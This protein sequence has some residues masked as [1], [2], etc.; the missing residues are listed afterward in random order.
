MAPVPGACSPPRKGWAETQGP[1]TSSPGSVVH[2]WPP[3]QCQLTAQGA[4]AEIPAPLGSPCPLPTQRSQPQISALLRTPVSWAFTGGQEKPCPAPALPQALGT[5]KRSGWG[6][7]QAWSLRGFPLPGSAGPRAHRGQ[8][9][10]HAQLYLEPTVAQV[11]P[12]PRGEM[13]R[14]E[15]HSEPLPVQRK[16]LPGL[17]VPGHPTGT[18]LPQASWGPPAGSRALQRREMPTGPGGKG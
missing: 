13:G 17:L 4:G 5:W 10:G 16:W 15:R 9:L 14:E 11:Y 1:A 18:S 8:N 7:Y 2:P 6:V 12:D 3:R